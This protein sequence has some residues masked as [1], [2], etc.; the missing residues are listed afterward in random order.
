MF[1]ELAGQNRG[2][3][4]S[5]TWL[6]AE[7]SRLT[8]RQRQVARLVALGL[9]NREIAQ[10]LVLEEGSVANLVARIMGRLGVS[11]RAQIA[12]WAAVNG[13]LRTPLSAPADPDRPLRPL[14]AR[15]RS[16]LPPRQR[17]S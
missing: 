7:P 13:L 1:H 9:T 17:A 2:D 12:T 14:E 16:V 4:I 10:V 15:A 5:A 3:R 11:N 8:P 6:K